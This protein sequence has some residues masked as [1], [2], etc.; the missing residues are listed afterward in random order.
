M[1]TL[2]TFTSPPSS[3]GYLPDQ[4][5]Q[6]EYIVV[7]SLS[8]AE[9]MERMRTGWRRFGHSIFRPRCPQCQACQSLRVP[10]EQFAPNRSQR[11]AW[12]AN[13]DLTLKVGPPTVTPAKLDLYDRFHEFQSEH[14]GWPGHPPKDAADYQS[15]FV[16]NPFRTEEWC[17]YLGPQ[18]IGVGYVDDLPAGLSAIYF[19]HDPAHRERSLGTYNVL[20]ILAAAAKRRLP[21]VYLGFFVADCASLAYK[22]NFTPNEVRLPTGQWVP[23][24]T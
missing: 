6:M 16:H 19:Y 22:A 9:Y 10:T 8:A 24:R 3:C 1:H 21:H 23:F 17:Y 13:A 4:Q 11:R 7:S 14:K 20:C 18:L 2:F 12:K 15:S 5:W